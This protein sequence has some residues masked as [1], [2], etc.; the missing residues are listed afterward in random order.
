MRRRTV[1]LGGGAVVAG[2]VAAAYR[3]RSAE[4]EPTIPHV[5]TGDERLRQ[6]YSAARARTVDFYTAV[7]AGYGD[8]NGLPVCLVLHGAS[9]T[10]ADFAGFGFGKFL[11]DSVRRGNPPFVLVGADGGKLSWQPTG[12]DDPQA[13]VHTEL[14]AWSKAEGFDT[15]RLAAWGWSMGGYGA[16]LLA[17][18]FPDSLRAVAALSPAI[19]RDDRIFTGAPML[20]SIPV[21]LWCG[22]QDG[23]YDEVH[24]LARACPKKPAIESYADGRHNFGYWSTCIPVV[25]DFVSHALKSAANSTEPA[26][27]RADQSADPAKSRTPR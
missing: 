5:P 4:P 2:A 10:P 1:L 24:A 17:E 6:R 22:K 14:P 16:L 7:P 15:S 23:L 3:T 27:T 25:F 21:G 11:T 18:T 20:R 13:M 12:A 19:S 9:A 8:G 26:P